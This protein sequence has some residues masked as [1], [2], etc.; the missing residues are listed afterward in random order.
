MAELDFTDVCRP[1]RCSAFL[2]K[3]SQPKERSPTWVNEVE[4]EVFAVLGRFGAFGISTR[5]QQDEN[6]FDTLTTCQASLSATSP[7]LAS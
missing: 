2:A 4:V 6:S 1:A 7:Y 5:F 3:A